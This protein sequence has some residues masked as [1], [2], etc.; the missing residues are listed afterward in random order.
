MEIKIT[1]LLLIGLLSATSL[2]AYA[3]SDDA[4]KTPPKSATTRGPVMSPDTHPSAP[5]GGNT[6]DSGAPGSPRGNAGGINGFGSGSGVGGGTGPAGGG[7][8]GAGGGT[9]SRWP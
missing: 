6:G 4:D 9:G 5:S 8:G 3:A 7:T 2:A 1:S